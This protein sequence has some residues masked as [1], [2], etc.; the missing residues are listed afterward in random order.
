M[1]GFWI[2]MEH[3]L[4]DKPEV[5]SLAATLGINDRDLIVGKLHRLW[6]WFD[7]HTSDG[8]APGVTPVFIDSLV[9]LEGFA[10]ALQVV[11]WLSTRRD[12]V[13]MPKFDRHNSKS[14]KD[15]AL[16]SERM[17]RS[18]YAASA[19]KTLPE[20]S[21]A[22][23][24]SPCS[25]PKEAGQGFE[26]FWDAF[27]KRRRTAK[28]KAL[29]AWNRAVKLA[30]PDDLVRAAVEYAES[31]VGRG[32]YVKMPSSWLNGQC[33]LDDRSAWNPPAPASVGRLPT[34][35]ED[36]KWDAYKGITQ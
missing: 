14:A 4:R 1:A 13:A 11:G 21:R 12:S 27:P 22:D 35:E 34:P 3:D 8:C 28:A 31:E 32:E 6:S 19:T 15:R 33:W 24:K 18:R 2:K 25:P 16:A 23:S 26:R 9:D 10:S 7:K 20:Q 17:K 5:I 29:E 36:A 30:S